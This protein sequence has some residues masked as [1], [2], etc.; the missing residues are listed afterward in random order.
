MEATNISKYRRGDVRESNYRLLNEPTRLKMRTEHV[1][2]L[3]ECIWEDEGG[4]AVE[5]VSEMTTETY[6]KQLMRV[7]GARKQRAARAYRPIESI[8]VVKQV[9]PM[10]PNQLEKSDPEL[11][12]SVQVA[13]LEA[14]IA[15]LMGVAK[16]QA[17]E[18]RR[19]E[20]SLVRLSEYFNVKRKIKVTQ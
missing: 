1:L 5:L 2:S 16:K 3:E 14:R 10:T 20:E 4:P 11:S 6:N 17:E 19:K 18:R 8:K 13:A 15:A 7:R 9:T 12:Q